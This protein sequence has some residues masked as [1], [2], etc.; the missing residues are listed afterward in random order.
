MRERLL[1]AAGF[2]LARRAEIIKQAIEAQVEALDAESKHGPNYDARLR[3]ASDLESLFGAQPSRAST[4]SAPTT[5]VAIVV[6][7]PSYAQPGARPQQ[8]VLTVA[9]PA[10]PAEDLGFPGS[11]PAPAPAPAPASPAP[12][13]DDF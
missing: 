4:G 10:A 11:A 7:L 12:D 5:Q 1:E 6:E 8:A 13:D 9:P 2:P 3:A